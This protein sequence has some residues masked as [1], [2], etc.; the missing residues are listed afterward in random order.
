LEFDSLPFLESQKAANIDAD[1][2]IYELF[3]IV[4]HRGGA[5]G[6]HYYANIRD[7]L[8]EGDWDQH[9]KLYTENR[10]KEKARQ[11]EKEREKQLIKEVQTKMEIESKEKDSQNDMKNLIEHEEEAKTLKQIVIYLFIFAKNFLTAITFSL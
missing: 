8:N 2:T 4:V 5:H 10:Q 11:E 1:D 7:C 6:G 3:A 9:M